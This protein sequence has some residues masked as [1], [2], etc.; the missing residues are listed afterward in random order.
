MSI[1][2]SSLLGPRKDVLSEWSSAREYQLLKR[3][4]TDRVTGSISVKMKVEIP[5][6]ETLCSSAVKETLT[7]KQVEKGSLLDGRVLKSAIGNTHS[8]P[9]FSSVDVS[10]LGASP[11]KK[12]YGTPVLGGKLSARISQMKRRGS[13]P[14]TE[15]GEAS[16]IPVVRSSR[17]IRPR[18]SPSETSNSSESAAMP[19]AGT[20]GRTR[21]S[22]ETIKVHYAE[23]RSRVTQQLQGLEAIISQPTDIMPNYLKKKET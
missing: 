12:S 5:T 23:A 15:S 9:L 19:K 14:M 18:E 13:D 10:L 6:F 16:L 7:P 11:E 1:F 4:A 3:N 8:D 20:D 2:L 21:S 17:L 22:P